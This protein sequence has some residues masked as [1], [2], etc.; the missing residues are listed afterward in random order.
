M[1]MERDRPTAYPGEGRHCQSGQ[2][3]AAGSP[4]DCQSSSQ[5]TQAVRYHRRKTEADDWACLLLRQNN[6]PSSNIILQ[7]TAYLLVLKALAR[8]SLTWLLRQR[9]SLLCSPDRVVGVKGALPIR[10]VGRAELARRNKPAQALCLAPP[11][12]ARRLLR[13]HWPTGACTKD[14]PK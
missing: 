4:Q 3:K 6:S 8:P 5:G 10:P 11:E 7:C 12:T 9:V 14:G 2:D 13:H 1:S